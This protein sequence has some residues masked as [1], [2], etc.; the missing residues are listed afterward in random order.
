MWSVGWQ[1]T[2]RLA[3][4]RTPAGWF[5]TLVVA[6]PL[7]AH[8]HVLRIACLLT[9]L[10]LA[11]ACPP[12]TLPPAEVLVED[13]SISSVAVTSEDLLWTAAAGGEANNTGRVMRLHRRPWGAPE[14]LA[15]QQF[16]PYSVTIGSRGIYWANYGDIVSCGELMALGE[17]GV[18][19]R[20]ELGQGC[21]GQVGPALAHDGT[22][23]VVRSLTGEVVVHDLDEATGD[24]LPDGLVADGD[25]LVALSRTRVEGGQ[26][27]RGSRI[28]SQPLR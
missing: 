25:D 16:N 28:L 20:I 10:A 2:T 5:R 14:L 9:C 21:E 15:S 19:R 24:Y 12:S 13:R 22:V 17:D 18:P 7:H 8:G 23:T 27:I 4:T 3:I 1:V 6:G 11:S 26:V